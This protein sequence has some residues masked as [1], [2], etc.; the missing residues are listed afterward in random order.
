[1]QY[2]GEVFDERRLSGPGFTSGEAMK[3]TIKV[4]KEFDLEYLCVYA[5]VRYWED[6]EVNGVEDTDGTLIPCRS[7][8]RWCPVIDIETGVIMNWEQGKE[9]KIHYK[10]C[11]A[12]DY[13]VEDKQKSFLLKIEGE[14]APS[15]LNTED[16]DGDYI[17][18]DVDKHGQIAGWEFD[19]CR[20]TSFSL[21][22]D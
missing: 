21:A 5:E 17:V 13:F 2:N 6:A 12:G 1:M 3:R 16:G 7:G 8:D 15:F 11:D 10:V 4:K 9:A 20:S 14:Y 19:P 18:F 22:S